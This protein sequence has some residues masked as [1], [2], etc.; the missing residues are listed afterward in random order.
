MKYWLTTFQT[1]DLNDMWKVLIATEKPFAASASEEI[2]KVASGC[3]DIELRF[4]ESYT[5]FDEIKDAIKDVH[6]LIVRSDKVRE[7]LIQS[8]PDLKL[9]IRAGSGYDNIDLEA[10]TTRGI[11]VMNTPG[12]NANAVAELAFGLMVTIIR[13]KFNGLP[14]SELKNKNLGLHGYGNIGHCMAQIARGFEMNLFAYDPYVTDV[15]DGVNLVED[16]SELYS[17]CDFISLSIP[18]N[19]ETKFSINYDLLQKTK[20]HTVLVNTARKEIIDE[21]G[22]LKIMSERPDF[23]YCSDIPPANRE[24]FES[25][26]GERCLITRKKMGAQTAE[27]NTNAGVAAITQVIAFFETGNTRFQIN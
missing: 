13:N 11:A 19:E 4:L 14:G 5:S 27:A 20:D 15:I 8:A 18:V 24:K 7:E 21:E 16:I 12:Q 17:Q 10:A 26:F 9:I 2:I 3:S 1:S 22:L 6:A 23:R 25:L